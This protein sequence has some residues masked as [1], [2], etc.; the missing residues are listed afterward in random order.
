MTYKLFILIPII[1][2][3]SCNEDSEI[4]DLLSSNSAYDN[5]SGIDK[6][7]KSGNQK[8]VPILLK[9]AGNAHATSDFRCYGCTVYQQSM[10]SLKSL[11]H[12]SPPH[13]IEMDVDS[14][15]IQFFMNYWLKHQKQNSKL[16]TISNKR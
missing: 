16:K 7:G 14:V 2:F 4:K 6:A 12:V 1:F 3:L 15:N 8:Y 10:Y 13:K 9:H 5:I 11:L